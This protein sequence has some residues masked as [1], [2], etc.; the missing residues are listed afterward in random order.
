MTIELVKI[1]EAAK[2]HYNLSME[3]YKSWEE[4]TTKREREYM[5]NQSEQEEEKCRGLLE[6]YQ[7]LTGRDVSIHGISKELALA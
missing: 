3:F 5:W 6:A 1:L 2:K 4:A 7:I